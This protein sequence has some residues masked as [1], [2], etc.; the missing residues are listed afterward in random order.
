M[1]QGALSGQ[2]TSSPMNV[3]A[4][5]VVGLYVVLLIAVRPFGSLEDMVRLRTHCTTAL[6][7]SRVSASRTAFRCPR[8]SV[9]LFVSLSARAAGGCANPQLRMSLFARR[10]RVP[11]LVRTFPAAIPAPNA[12][13]TRLCTGTRRVSRT[14]SSTDSRGSRSRTLSRQ[15]AQRSAALVVRRVVAAM[16]RPCVDLR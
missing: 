3:S 12:P 7:T 1:P 15:S 8:L 6:G 13:F 2:P 10:Q 11:Q 5:I 16:Q 9:C 14:S 4:L